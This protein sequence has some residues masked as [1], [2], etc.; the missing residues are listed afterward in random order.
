MKMSAI[1]GAARRPK[2]M[3]CPLRSNRAITVAAQNRRLALLTNIL[4]RDSDGAVPV[5]ARNI[6]GDSRAVLRSVRREGARF[7]LDKSLE[8]VDLPFGHLYAVL[9]FCP[10]PL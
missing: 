9:P 10:H 4:S 1:I 6:K 8:P 2:Q 5:V 7:A 3:H